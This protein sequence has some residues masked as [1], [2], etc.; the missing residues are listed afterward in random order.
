MR[1]SHRAIACNMSDGNN[2][3][4]PRSSDSHDA[5]PIFSLLLALTL[6]S[7]VCLLAGCVARRC[8]S[9]PL[10]AWARPPAFVH[11][12]WLRA[13]GVPKFT[14]MHAF[15]V[16]V[17]ESEWAD[18]AAQALAS[19]GF[20]ALRA[21]S[22]SKPPVATSLCARGAATTEAELAV[23]LTLAAAQVSVHGDFGFRE[24][25][26]RAAQSRRFDLNWA[27]ALQRV[28]G[29][30]TPRCAADLPESVAEVVG[31][32]ACAAD[33]IVQPVLARWVAPDTDADDADVGAASEA[34]TPHMIGCVDSLPEAP[35]QHWHADGWQ[36]GLFTVFVPLV[37]VTAAKGP[38]ELRPG[39][40]TKDVVLGGRLLHSGDPRVESARPLLRAG[41]VLIFDFRVAHRGTAN[42]SAEARPLMYLVY[43]TRQGVRD[44]H[45]FLTRWPE[46]RRGE[47]RTAPDDD[48]QNE[49]V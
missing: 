46:L 43:S 1:S 16:A 27:A 49:H 47:M 48:A 2:S 13:K 15:E 23:L 11:G 25:C 31:E 24:I 22:P 18:A 33:A 10:P 44:R 29:G 14:P 32:L 42:R 20:V 3:I 5:S 40:H 39:S 6:T 38:T 19:N 36:E 30:E 21:L 12:L 4:H 37:D 28:K 45:N 17:G 8:R 35:H 34:P 26:T 7:L 41:E 9:R